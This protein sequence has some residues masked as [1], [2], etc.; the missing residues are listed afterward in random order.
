M[1]IEK[2]NYTGI[3]LGTM[4]QGEKG[5]EKIEECRRIRGYDFDTND[6]V[7]R[8]IL[9]TKIHKKQRVFIVTTARP[10][11]VAS[12]RL[13]LKCTEHHSWIIERYGELIDCRTKNLQSGDT[14]LYIYYPK[15]R[16]KVAIISMTETDEYLDMVDIKVKDLDNYMLGSNVF[17]N[18][19]K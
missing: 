10:I 3:P 17:T 1:T 11:L 6:I 9:D 14:L 13:I 19:R 4:I 15:E 16:A 2:I 7:T 12:K 8:D 18:D 5:L